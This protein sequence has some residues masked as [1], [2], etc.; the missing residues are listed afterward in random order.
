MKIKNIYRF[1]S[2][3]LI[4]AFMFGGLNLFVLNQSVSAKEAKEV[5]TQQETFGSISQQNN[6]QDKA[7][8]YYSAGQY[9]EAIKIWNDKLISTSDK[10]LKATLHN[11]LGSAYR[12]IGNLG[13]AINEWS[14]AAKIYRSMAD[15]DA[16]IM[17]AKVLTEQAQAYNAIGQPRNALPI[18]QSALDLAQKQQQLNI[19]AAVNGIIGNSYLS[20]GDYKKSIA[21]HQESLKIAQKLNNNQLIVAAWNNLGNAYNGRSQRYLLQFNSATVE[22]DEKERSRISDLKLSDA[23]AAQA[24][25][26]NS[27][28]FSQAIGGIQEAKASLNLIRFLRQQ[29]STPTEVIT[30][31]S[32][33]VKSILDNV[34]DSRAKAYALINLAEIQ[35]RDI[36]Q[37][38]IIATL[39]KAITVARNINDQRSESFAL[40]ALGQ[41]YE[42]TKN[43]D[44]AI[45]SS[46]KA[47]FAAQKINAPDSLYRAQALAARV[48]QARGEREAAIL[49]YK[50]SINTLQTI[51]GD[52]SVASKDLQFD[53]R[54]SV[55]P[56]Y[57]ELMA[58]L[59]QGTGNQEVASS[60]KQLS[61]ESKNHNL[62]NN[63]AKNNS[64]SK[65]S[66]ALQ[67]SEL[68]QLSE[69]QN[70]FGDECIQVARN[71]ASQEDLKNQSTVFINSVILS[72][73]TYMLLGLAN[74]EYKSYPIPV[75]ESELEKEISRLRYTLENIAT[76]EY[77]TETRKLYDWLI[78]PMA[79]DIAKAKPNTLVFIND[80]VLR[81]V[82]MAALHDGKQFL[83]EKYA[84]AN[85]LGMNLTPSQ[86]TSKRDLKAAIFGLSVEVPPF[87]PLP[88]VKAEAEGLKK[89]LGGKKFLDEQFTLANLQ[90]E[91]DNNAY[92]IVHLATHGKFGADPSSTFLQLFNERL[93]L[94]EFENVL[95]RSKQPIK[96]LTLS[97][98]QTA[99][100]DS[101]STL[102]IA[103]VAL[104]AG[105]Q[106]TLATLWFVN[107]A[108]T[109][110]LINDFYTQMQKPGM[111][112]AEALRQAQLKVIQNP[113]GHPAIWSPF[114]LAGNWL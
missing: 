99:A 67:V 93:S 37:N 33:K 95:R 68:L 48:Y 38:E 114:V 92:P 107:D 19:Q 79:S 63:S 59:L 42:Q 74:G 86:Q 76:D 44:K 106:S 57:R 34:S 58:L 21:S 75:S 109:V 64:A 7:V 88:N 54:D 56:V 103:G 61:L 110:P 32:D 105:V 11:N 100:G 22:G 55:E 9:Q 1:L 60:Y 47:Q 72:N 62:D 77:I 3:V 49:A 51:R 26:E 29:K 20:I 90:K 17:L 82:P 23:A 102:G 71:S 66:E 73:Q 98:C 36:D 87:A 43:W 94:P 13:Q 39:E 46:Q 4:S 70:F 27:V 53:L 5:S 18:L 52:I 84:I 108:D 91:I 104:R 30:K 14:E 81:N 69:L 25:Y 89:L 40:T 31:Y 50:Q 78:R 65:I 96:L 112:K 2:L 10:K 12:Q 35:D 15:K 83:V 80:G 111:S 85:T 41:V 24:A 28:Q 16:A 97:A 8:N 6:P 45:E 113:D 101:R